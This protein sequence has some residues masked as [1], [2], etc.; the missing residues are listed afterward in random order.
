MG[1]S[2]LT[3]QRQEFLL[4][5]PT[6][7]LCEHS[8]Q[9]YIYKGHDSCCSNTAVASVVQIFLKHSNAL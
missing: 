8:F 1:L 2:S 9:K 6:A 3:M 7:K 5:A 4:L